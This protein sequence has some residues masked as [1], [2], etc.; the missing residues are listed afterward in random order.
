MAT[1]LVIADFVLPLACADNF[2]LPKEGKERSD[3]K[4]CEE[5]N[6]AGHTST[7]RNE[8][9]TTANGEVDDSM[10]EGVEGVQVRLA[11]TPLL[12]NL[13]KANANA[14]WMD[15]TVSFDTFCPL[16]HLIFPVYEPYAQSIITDGT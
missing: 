13:G 15:L 12:A 6:S 7:G 2:G 10:T 11:P 3:G 14:Y 8:G 5:F 16:N 1:K 9:S 4:F